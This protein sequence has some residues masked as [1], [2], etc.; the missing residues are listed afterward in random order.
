MTPKGQTRG[1]R[2]RAKPGTYITYIEGAGEIRDLSLE[3][4]FVLD[5]SPLPVGT[6]MSFTLH[7]GSQD[8]ALQGIVRH[9][10]ADRGMG[11]QFADISAE[12]KSRLESYLSSLL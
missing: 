2:F 6:K 4:L 5:A 9:S 11:I 10:I 3:G 1:L 8:I 7:L 12:V